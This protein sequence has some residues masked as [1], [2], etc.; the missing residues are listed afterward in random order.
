MGDE[1]KEEPAWRRKQREFEQ[2]KARAKNAKLR[3]TCTICGEKAKL[4]CPC[5]TTQCAPGADATRAKRSG[6]PF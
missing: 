2:V 6:R 5:E 3:T 4:K 1:N